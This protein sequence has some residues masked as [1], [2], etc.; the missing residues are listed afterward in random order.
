MIFY[1]N[2]CFLLS[3][4]QWYLLVAASFVVM[5]SSIRIYN[6]DNNSCN[7]GED[8]KYCRRIKFGLSLG[9]AAVVFGMVEIVLSNWGKL[10]VYPEAGL[11]FMLF[12]LYIVGIA[13]ITFGGNVG[14]GSNIGNLYFST[15]LGFVLT[16]FL[17]SK[18]FNAVRDKKKGGEAEA[19]EAEGGE[20]AEASGDDKKAEDAPEAPPEAPVEITGDEKA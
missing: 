7:D 14:P 18:S 20:K 10:S 17:T 11:T 2:I 5:T 3:L 12:V 9:A 13:I 1:S 15:W 4:A 19:E 6:S 16:L 8:S